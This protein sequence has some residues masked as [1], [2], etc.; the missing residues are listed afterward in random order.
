MLVKQ[1]SVF[2]ENKTGRLKEI[3]KLLGENNIDIRALSIADTTDF[4][5]LRMI[6]SDPDNAQNVLK[7]NNYTVTSTFVIAIAV[8]DEPGGLF[9]AL[10]FLDENSIDIDYMYA[11]VGKKENQALVILCV[12]KTDEAIKALIKNN[13]KVLKSQ[14][15][16]GL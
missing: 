7:K 15:V 13:V 2:L 8:T 9:G 16:Y 11:F 3:T 6:V 12:D 5:V 14:E 1:I 4:G 10:T